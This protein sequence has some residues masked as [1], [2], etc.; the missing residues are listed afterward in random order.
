MGG[1]VSPW[2]NARELLLSQ[3]GI[4]VSLDVASLVSD[5]S[6][7]D[8]SFPEPQGTRKLFFYRPEEKVIRWWHSSLCTE[9]KGLLPRLDNEAVVYT[10]LYYGICLAESTTYTDTPHVLVILNEKG[11]LI[12]GI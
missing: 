7:T 12:F 11:R 4:S 10:L 2:L 1:F 6:S 3:V 8:L 5:T 9:C